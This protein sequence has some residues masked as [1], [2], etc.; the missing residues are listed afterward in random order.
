MK[1][2]H[3]IPAVA[4]QYGG[5]SKV[6][7]TICQNLNN[8]GIEA[9]IVT[10]NAGFPKNKYPLNKKFEY[11][12]IETIFFNKQLSESF[13]YSRPL[14]NWLNK[15][16][17]KYDLVHIHAIF[18]HSSIAASNACIKSKVPYI[19]RPLGSLDPWSLN[20]RKRLKKILFKLYVTKMINNASM[21]HY[22]TQTE[23]ELA[24]RK[25]SNKSGFIIP[26]SLDDSFLN[27]RNGLEILKKY[28]IEEPYI[29][30]LSRIHHKKGLEFLIKAFNKLVDNERFKY[31]KLIIAGDGQKDYVEEIKKIADKNIFFT[32]WLN[33]YEKKALIS[34]SK[35]LVLP[36]YQENFGLCLIEALAMKVPVL[37][38]KN[39][40]LWKEIISATAGWICDPN[41]DSIY[42]LLIEILENEEKRKE[43]GNNGRKLIENNFTDEVVTEKLI[44]M[45]NLVL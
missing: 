37:T 45:Y 30:F 8:N 38:T 25:I 42:N 40:N 28:K 17:S 20:Q 13:K 19:L 3:V 26:L 18:S 23:Q 22:T 33:D 4:P 6:V 2:L 29:L 11:E 14:E 7:V 10:T 43:F 32:G 44:D 24:E 27:F 5:P 9:K 35:L 39:V 34:N 21:I 16:V 1:I 12:G 15:N 31:L 41:A 36:S